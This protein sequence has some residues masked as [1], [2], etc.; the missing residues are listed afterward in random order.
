MQRCPAAT[1]CAAVTV[2]AAGRPPP[3][4]LALQR[5]QP[6]QRA[7]LEDAPGDEA[8]HRRGAPVRDARASPRAQQLLAPRALPR[9]VAPGNADRRKQPRQRHPPK[10]L[11]ARSLRVEVASCGAARGGAYPARGRIPSHR[12]HT[13]PVGAYPARGGAYPARGRIPS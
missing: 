5:H 9:G 6:R 10:L 8:E 11:R 12:A 4:F 1:R 3:R 2:P 7:R 13:Q